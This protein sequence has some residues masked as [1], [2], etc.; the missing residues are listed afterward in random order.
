[1]AK[2]SSKKKTAAKKKPDALKALK[3]RYPHVRSVTATGKRGP[4]RIEIG[5]VEDGCSET[6]EI[7]TQDA[8]QVQRCAACQ[9][10][11]AKARRRKTPATVKSPKA[12]NRKPK[13]TTGRK[14]ATA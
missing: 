6:R 7:A 5:C 1:M 2:K 11:F 13:R 10:E 3:A 8:F 4:T 12:R 14:R 9:R